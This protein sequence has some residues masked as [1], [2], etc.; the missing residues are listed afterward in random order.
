MEHLVCGLNFSQFGDLRFCK[1]CVNGKQ[2]RCK[3]LLASEHR[4]KR[5]L[6]FFHSDVCGR[7]S[8]PSISGA[9]YFVTFTE[10]LTRYVWVYVLKR[11]SE[12]FNAFKEWKT[13][14]E[15][16]SGYEVKTI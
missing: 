11:K 2:H 12:V 13:L 1:S 5:P 15:K 9:E 4:T 14:V 6:E 7:I 10:D 16:S 3:F 8:V